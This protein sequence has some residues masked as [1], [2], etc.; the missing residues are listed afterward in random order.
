[1]YTS[2]MQSP[3]YDDRLIF[4]IDETSVNIL[5]QCHSKLLE[6]SDSS[7]VPII[8]KAE[9]YASTTLVISIASYGAP[10][11]STLIWPQATVPKELVNLKGFNIAIIA[12]SS[13]WQ[14]KGTFEQT[15]L[16]VSLPQMVQRRKDLNLTEKEIMLILDGHHSRLSLLFI[17]ACIRWRITVLVIPA[18]TSSEIQ[19]NDCGVNGAFKA[20]FTKECSRRTTFSRR[21][22]IHEQT[23]TEQQMVVPQSFPPPKQYPANRVPKS[24]IL[25]AL[26]AS[27][28]ELPLPAL[29]DQYDFDNTTTRSQ[30]QREILVDVI[31]RALEKALSI[32]TIT[33]SWRT[34]GLLP[35]G[36]GK[37]VVLSKLPEGPPPM[38]QN[39]SYPTIS[40]RMLT[41]QELVAEIWEWQ[42]RKNKITAEED[43]IKQNLT[44]IYDAICQTEDQFKGIFTGTSITEDAINEEAQ[45]QLK[46]VQ[47]LRQSR[48][49]DR[50]RVTE[51]AQTTTHASETTAS[52]ETQSELIILGR[53]FAL[54]ELA[55]IRE[56]TV[57]EYGDFISSLKASEQTPTSTVLPP[58]QGTKATIPPKRKKRQRDDLP[59]LQQ[60]I[61]HPESSSDTSHSDK[62]Y[63]IRRRRVRQQAEDYYDDSEVSILLD[64]H[65]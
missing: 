19:P 10:L 22:P 57:K 52:S 34:A 6:R 44:S 59:R 17:Y 12:N 9:R 49:A 35:I 54:T 29:F 58:E 11:T 45:H 37:D 25:K 18:H 30:R 61:D 21:E 50:R 47:E 51:Q 14:T 2:L 27:E 33:S 16:E 36:T 24:E 7:T 23:Q 42:L 63:R 13:G 46:A 15:M 55:K 60:R 43:Y 28:K 5:D 53:R 20:A 40:G 8:P 65:I 64:G 4:N 38:Q 1:M 62:P 48:A 3:N 31:P 26:N 41:S 39:R 56:M 32:S